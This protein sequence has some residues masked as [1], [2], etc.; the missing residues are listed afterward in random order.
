VAIA[1]KPINPVPVG[2]PWLPES[3][4][5]LVTEIASAV[6]EHLARARSEEIMRA[7]HPKLKSNTIRAKLTATAPDGS[8]QWLTPGFWV[9]EI[10]LVLL[11]GIHNGRHG[12][13]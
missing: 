4:T 7:L 8:P 1:R 12:Q 9:K 5:I 3:E 2:N 11:E 13:G 10:A 6:S